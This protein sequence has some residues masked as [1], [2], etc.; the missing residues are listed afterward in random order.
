M[1]DDTGIK[2]SPSLFALKEIA[3]LPREPIDKLKS[4]ILE[5][6]NQLL[7]AQKPEPP[8]SKYYL[9][10]SLDL[11]CEAMSGVLGHA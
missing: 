2:I 11:T 6:Y 3:N 5:R 1:S 8:K 9:P 10:G 4:Q 7:V